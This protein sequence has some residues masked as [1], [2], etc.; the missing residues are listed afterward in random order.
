MA[1]MEIAGTYFLCF[2]NAHV[3]MKSYMHS[4]GLTQLLLKVAYKSMVSKLNEGMF[5]LLQSSIRSSKATS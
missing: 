4:Q 2:T 1:K 5:N 3:Q